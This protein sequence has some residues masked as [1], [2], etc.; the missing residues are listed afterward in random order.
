MEIKIVKKFLSLL[1]VFCL[2][3]MNFSFASENRIVYQ[4][5]ET[6]VTLLESN[7]EYNKVMTVSNNNVY[8]GMY[9][10]KTGLLEIFDET[11]DS[12][13]ISLMSLNDDKKMLYTEYVNDGDLITLK[14]GF[15]SNV[16]ALSGNITR[17]NKYVDIDMYYYYS[18]STRTT[19]AP[20]YIVN[21][22]H[23]SKNGSE[24]INNQ[25]YIN[26]F[27]NSVDTMN[28]KTRDEIIAQ[29][30]SVGA[31]AAFFAGTGL[32]DL[33]IT[34]LAA[35]GASGAAIA[36]VLDFRDARD[37]ANSSFNAIRFN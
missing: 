31:V 13:S 35:I 37:L 1:I 20:Y 19:G 14:E 36:I 17:S 11:E 8:I 30:A 4:D 23:I 2:V 5:S 18:Q 24:S 27:M 34:A 7:A 32:F 15:S 10:K 25:T 29:F 12:N 6:T 16:Q 28:S 3:F 22:N 21:V 33:A 9:D 26:Q